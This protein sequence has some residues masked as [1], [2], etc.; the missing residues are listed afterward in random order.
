M[1]G[2][3]YKALADPT[4]RKILQLLRQRDMTAGELAAHFD[5]AKPT[6]S[7][8]FAVLRAADL[9]QGDKQGTTITYRLN[10]TVLEETMMTMM[11]MFGLDKSSDT[12]GHR[13]SAENH[14]GL[15]ARASQ[16]SGETEGESEDRHGDRDGTTND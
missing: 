1:A 6:L 8:H 12:E 7:R 16:E 9:I 11:D 3:V 5:F 10:V 13:G 15:S 14:R 2:N 4:R